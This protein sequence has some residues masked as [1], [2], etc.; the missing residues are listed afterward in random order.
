MSSNGEM[1]TSA[2]NDICLQIDDLLPDYAMGLLDSADVMLVAT[3]LGDCPDQA[4]HLLVLDDAFAMIGLAANEQEPT[5]GLWHRISASLTPDSAQIASATRS[6]PAN[7]TTFGDRAMRIPR[8]AGALAAILLVALISSTIGLGYAVRHQ[9]AKASP[10]ESTMATY[11]TSGGT[12]IPLAS[13][14]APADFE[15]SGK[16]ALIV[17]PNMPPLLVVDNCDAMNKEATY[18]VWLAVADQRTP[19]G[20]IYVDSKGRGMLT[21]TGIDSLTNYDM[22]GISV[23][24]DDGDFYDLIEGSPNREI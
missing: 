1:T 23:K 8:W 2:P 13:K 5:P 10:L 7:G 11:M 20:K 15:W 22:I 4:A 21:I 16:G 3:H 24:M 17:A 18:V 9:P 6:A 14:A 12:V 19:M